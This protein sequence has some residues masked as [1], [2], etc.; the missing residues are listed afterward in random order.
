M[1]F[2]GGAGS[3]CEATTER[4]MKKPN[5]KNGIIGAISIL[6][7]MIPIMILAPLEN[8]YANLADFMFASKDFIG[9]FIGVT[10]AAAVIMFVVAG[11]LNEKILRIVTGIMAGIGIAIYSQVMFLNKNLSVSN[12]SSVNFDNMTKLKLINGA[13]WGLIV[14][15]ML[16]IVI[17]SKSNWK[18]I[19][20]FVGGGLCAVQLVAAISLPF[21]FKVE[22]RTYRYEL[23]AKNEFE[24]AKGENIL[25]FILDTVGNEQLK[26]AAEWYEDTLDGLEDFTYYTNADCCYGWT[27]PSMTHM[28]TGK[29]VNFDA[30]TM[31]VWNDEAWN[32]DKT[33][34]YYN[35]LHNAGYE[36]DMY[37]GDLNYIFEDAR[38]LN[39]KFDNLRKYEHLVNRRE[40]RGKMLSYALYKTLPYALKSGFQ[41][42]TKD[43]AGCVSAKVEDG[44]RVADTDIFKFMDGVNGGLTFSDNDKSVKI[45]HLDGTH[46]PIL[47]DENLEYN[48]EALPQMAVNAHFKILKS[49]F[50]EMKKLSVYDDATII[51]TADHG[52]YIGINDPQ[53]ILLVKEKN[54]KR[55]EMMMNS[56]PVSHKELMPSILKYAGLEYGDYGKCYEDYSENEKRKRTLGY[57]SEGHSYYNFYEY[58]G[59]ES[60]LLLK[61]PD[62]PDYT[63]QAPTYLVNE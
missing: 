3:Y 43:F 5:I 30:P 4:T 12:G 56:A 34:E 18:D 22:D 2:R 23:S 61:F 54:S 28:L 33:E 14:V 62:N 13:C 37:A 10:V 48:T 60:D 7:V 8:Y 53:P 25:I 46:S 52:T 21:S 50:D 24:V 55:T 6:M 27:R 1:Y 20:L 11:Y 36:V 9:M 26:L 45:F 59:D 15:V 57:L 63:K 47:I 58:E 35:R 19:I 38:N 49:Y 39:G 16:V 51:I 44:D 40:V 41:V 42:V 32:C 17:K 29:D 31:Y